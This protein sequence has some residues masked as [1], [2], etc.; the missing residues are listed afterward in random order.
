MI[1]QRLIF[2]LQ[3]YWRISRGATLGVR[4]L[5]LNEAGEVML[6]RH[7]YTPGWFLPGGGI[8]HNQTAEQALSTELAEEAGIEITGPPELLG[9][10]SN[11]AYFKY[12]HVLFYRIPSWKLC[13]PS[14][15]KVEITDRRFFPLTAL[16]E[17]TTRATRARLA[18]VFEGAPRSADW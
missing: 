13:P 15:S 4:G 11:H 5:A 17:D 12:D 7:G 14:A 2:L 16:P 8:E 10:Y 6:V 18:E 9:V 1:P 3:A